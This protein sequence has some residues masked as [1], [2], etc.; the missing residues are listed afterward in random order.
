ML[1]QRIIT[2]TI[3]ASLLAAAVFFLPSEYFSLLIA[4]IT[5]AGAWEWA[6]LAGIQSLPK[7]LLFLALLLVPMLGVFFWTQLLEVIAIGFDW[8][9]VRT[10]SGV[11]EWLVVPPVLFW[12]LAMILIRK[13]PL[14]V[15]HLQVKPVY[16]LLAGWFV[17]VSVWMFMSR[18]KAFYGAEMMMYFLLLIWAA[19]IAA[20]FVG[21][22]YGKT[23][24]APDI[25]P[26]KTVEG[27]YGA[28]IAGAV[29][30]IILSLIYGFNI[31]VASDF[32]LLSVLTVLISIYGDLFISVL[33]RQRGVKDSGSLLPGH[34]GILDRID[35]LVAATPFF[36]AGIF[37][38]YRSI[39]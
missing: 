35:S 22:K 24:L 3:L 34:G 31:L 29:C 11:L 18:I 7:K 16:K 32:V 27:M 4:L 37:L 20:Y 39:E 33:K 13:A 23:K 8:T 1:Q 38:I 19:D 5:L 9:D 10:Y 26:G 25:S 15:L 12:I 28:L 14:E 30:A 2:A 36:Y 6:Y 17:L 21:R